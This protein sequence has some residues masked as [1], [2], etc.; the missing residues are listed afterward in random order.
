MCSTNGYWGVNR[1]AAVERI[2]RLKSAGLGAI[3]FSTGQMHARFVPPE[4]IVNAAVAAFDAGVKEVSVSIEDFEET[5][6]D[7]RTITENPEIAERRKKGLVVFMRSWIENAAGTG[8]ATLRHRARQ[9][10]FRRDVISGCGTMLDT[11]TV[12]PDLKLVSCCGY[13][14]ESVTDLHLGSVAER[15]LKEILDAAEDDL[16]KLWIHVAGPERMLMFVKKYL[17]NYRLPRHYVD[18]CQTCVHMHRDPA[19]MQV[20]REHLHEVA[21]DVTWV[22]GKLR[23]SMGAYPRVATST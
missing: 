11:I 10:R 12:T 16:I 2:G 18:I 3:S 19:V 17:P 15:T 1:K 20:L 5:T 9:G 7:W 6:F 22:Y 4:R 14:I 21:D 13:P 23:D 8:T